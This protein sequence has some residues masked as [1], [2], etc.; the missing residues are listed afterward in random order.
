MGLAQVIEHLL[1]GRDDPLP[2]QADVIVALGET[3]APERYQASPQTRRVAEVAAFYLK[4]SFPAVAFIGRGYPPDVWLPRSEAEA[5]REVASSF[6]DLRPFTVVLEKE[7]HDTQGNI[8]ALKR[9]MDERGW[10]SAVVVAQ[11]LHMA[12]VRAVCEELFPAKDGDDIRVVSAWSEYGGSSKWI[13]KSF[14]TFLLWDRVI[15]WAA[16]VV[17]GYI[18]RNPWRWYRAVY[19]RERVPG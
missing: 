4:D 15:A 16:F 18:S 1:V 5:M 2:P 8:V 11:Q 12:R 17:R 3:L 6:V 7:S 19:P 10:K 14:W 13:F 9:I